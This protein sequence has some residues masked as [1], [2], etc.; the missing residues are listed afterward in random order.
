VITAASTR[1]R[2][3][4]KAKSKTESSSS[5]KSNIGKVKGGRVSKLGL[6]KK[7][8]KTAPTPTKSRK[9]IQANDVPDSS[10]KLTRASSAISEANAMGP[11]ATM[12][13]PADMNADCPLLRLP[14]EIRN[15]IWLLSVISP[16]QLVI[17]NENPKQPPITRTCRQIRTESIRYFY[18]KNSF[19]CTISNYDPSNF[20]LY[21]K[22][23][24]KHGLSTVLLTHRH[25]PGTA[26]TVLRTNMLAWLE[27][28]FK[29]ETAPLGYSAGHNEDSFQWDKLS[30]RIV[31]VFNI[32]RSLK[33]M[34]VTWETAKD[35]LL[36]AVDAAGVC[37]EKRK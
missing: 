35:I 27:G 4:L 24:D 30:H 8:T 1:E 33:Y 14:A 9:A 15:E 31:K 12:S 13:A 3:D 20:K 17:S 11:D 18:N 36:N 21:R 37:G 34:N 5:G 16:D 7:S 26:R 28:T 29:G 22:H 6:A 32:A 19:T 25:E 10:V 23:A 2:R